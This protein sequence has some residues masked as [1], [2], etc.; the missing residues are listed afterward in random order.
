MEDVSLT[1]AK[2]H[3]EELVER[4]A[5]GEE[6]RISD[7]KLGTVRLMRVGTPNLLGPRVTDTME[8]FAPLAKDRVPGRLKGKMKV[9][10]RLMEPMSEEELRDWYG[11]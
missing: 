5:R 10:E 9:P 7:A 8:P 6:I 11:G 2:D 1:H 3:L 4:A